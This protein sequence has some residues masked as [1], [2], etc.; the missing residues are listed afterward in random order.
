M[1]TA[2]GM[3]SGFTVAEIRGDGARAR[4]MPVAA[5][6][7]RRAVASVAGAGAA[8]A[9]VVPARTV[10]VSRS[11]NH[12]PQSYQHDCDGDRLNAPRTTTA[13]KIARMAALVRRPSPAQFPLEC[14]GCNTAN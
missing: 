1:R 5:A 9:A 13:L 6:R 7:C 2:V 11:L 10:A 12:E 4:A 8:A 3:S 14:C